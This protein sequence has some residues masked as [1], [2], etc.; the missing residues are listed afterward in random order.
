VEH[1]Q[2]FQL[3]A[4]NGTG[5]VANCDVFS[6]KLAPFSLPLYTGLITNH[7]IYSYLVDVEQP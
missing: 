1:V 4:F 2:K 6:G 5:L 7:T 3:H